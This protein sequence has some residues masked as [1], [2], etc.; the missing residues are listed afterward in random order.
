[1]KKF[2]PLLLCALSL[3][4]QPIES[5]AIFHDSMVGKWF[6]HQRNLNS[7]QPQERWL[8]TSM[9]FFP[10][11]RCA[12]LNQPNSS[13][14][15]WSQDAT[16]MELKTFDDN[17]QPLQVWRGALANTN[18]LEGT[19]FVADQPV[20]KMFLM[21]DLGTPA[22]EAALEVRSALGF[23]N[24]Q[25]KRSNA[26]WVSNKMYF[27]QHGKCTIDEPFESCVWT[28]NLKELKASLKLSK[29][30]STLY[31]Y[32]SPLDTKPGFYGKIVDGFKSKKVVGEF[33][34]NSK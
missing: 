8:L 32:V 19:G 23:W 21:R 25:Y 11:G 13:Y 18:L 5:Q 7:I 30:D 34:L 17:G 16:V 1:M 9:E 33:Y 20:A 22:A 12:I 14:C 10:N 2:K 29:N 31:F 26:S 15:E 4:A 6:F 3:F 24:L 27:S 28:E